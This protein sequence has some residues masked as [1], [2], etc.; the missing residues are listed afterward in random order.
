[1]IISTGMADLNTVER[2]YELVSQINPNVPILQCTSSY[3]TLPENINLN[4]IRSYQR[5]FPNAVI[6][7]SGHETGTSIS[8]GAVI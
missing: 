4:V 6:G 5:D 7:Y 2:A 1:M 8:I 3:P